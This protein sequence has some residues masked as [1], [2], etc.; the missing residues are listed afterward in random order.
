MNI[1][2]P[3]GGIGKRFAE[4]GYKMPKPLINVLG[5]PM[6]YRVIESFK[7]QAENNHKIHIV[8]HSHL[9]D[10]NFETLI[11][12]YFPKLNIAFTC[13]ESPTKGA[14]ETVLVGLKD[15]SEEELNQPILI[16]DCDT[17][18]EENVIEKYLS[19][20][21][22]NCIFYFE[23]TQSLPLFS[24]IKVDNNLV[25]QIEEKIKISDWA[26]TGL[27]GFEN[28][29]LFREYCE[30]V[31]DSNKE[32]YISYVY[33]Q[34]IKAQLSI[35]TIKVT[36]FN[37]VGTPLQLKSYCN[38]N[39]SKVDTLRICFDL[40]NTL[41]THP[42]IAGDY[43]SVLPIYKNIDYLKLLKQL[44]ATIIIYTARRMK[45][46]K[47]NVGAI[48]ADVGKVT[49]ETLEK[50]GIPFDEIYFGKPYANFY[51][52]DLAVNAN[53]QLDNE[54]GVYNLD[55]EPRHFNEVKYTDK[56]VMKV[57]SNDGEVYWYKNIPKSIEQYFP[58]IISI[59]KNKIEM[60]RIDGVTY[61]YMYVNKILTKEHIKDLILT[62][63]KIHFSEF[64]DKNEKINIYSNYSEKI[65]KRWKDNTE[66]YSKY[67]L[68]D[69]IEYILKK[70]ELYEKRNRGS[71]GVIHGDSVFTNIIK[72]TIG[73]I[74]FIDMRG[75]Q[76]DTA[77]IF[78]DV[79]YDYAKIYQS[80]LGYDSILN[81]MEID[82]YYNNQIIEEFESYFFKSE[83]D[84]IKLI[85]ASL[86]ISLL[87]L[88]KDDESKFER[89]IS[90][91]NKLINV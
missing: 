68:T 31:L 59:N 23:D 77:T 18:Y 83:V 41:V 74:K 34:M 63:S 76:A 66:L 10:Y 39:K 1:I 49:L 13:L 46:H 65:K 27:Y 80:L 22:K 73:S 79:L 62:L 12:F 37:C 45:T 5:K 2:I 38:K 21:N 9:K 70:L 6:L 61:S 42:T 36:E 11:K 30:T 16:A 51:I 67:N 69:S 26:N 24:Y 60:E 53:T 81:G 91:I 35:T 56:S 40:D 87:P 20:I 43:S 44:G 71:I 78:G 32:V 50:Y 75:K 14:A 85:T 82:S 64:A 57:T 58:K 48:F 72:T 28:G 4:E 47:G 52:D 29:H 86:F 17:F 88:H 55:I 89:Y 8:Y 84:D 3:I 33:Q 15:F 90:I 7:L 19:S 54:I 25:T